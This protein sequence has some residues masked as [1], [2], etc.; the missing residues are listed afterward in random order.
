MSHSIIIPGRP[1]RWQ[2][3]KEVRLKSGGTRKFTDPEC[4]RH[5]ARVRGL[6]REAW[7]LKKPYTGPVVLGLRFVFEIPVSWPGYTRR[8]ALEG[9]VFYIA[10]P[11]LDQLVK[12]VMDALK[13]LAYVDD[14][15]VVG[16]S[17]CAKRYGDPER[18]EIE[19]SPVKIDEDA[20]TPGQR[21]LEAKVY[22]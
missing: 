8:A 9:R 4:E 10:D 5:K 17:H 12:Q 1:V 15:Q 2:R 19:L 18:T 7:R 13:G 11:D 16:F 21:R 3:A 20:V 14:N 6:C 22:G